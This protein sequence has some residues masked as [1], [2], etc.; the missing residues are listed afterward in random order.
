MA[1]TKWK[2]AGKVVR[3]AG[4]AVA[5]W[6]LL[7]SGG[8]LDE[9]S[10]V[11]ETPTLEGRKVVLVFTRAAA[12]MPQSDVAQCA[13]HIVNITAEEPDPSWITADYTTCEAR[14]DTWFTTIKAQ[15]NTDWTLKEY[16]W[17]RFGPLFKA[18]GSPRRVTT[19]GTVATGTGARLPDQVAAT[20]TLK[21]VHRK[22]WG[23]VYVPGIG[24]QALGS[25]GRWSNAI[26]TNYANATGVL[27]NGL[28]TDDFGLCVFSR[29]GT[30]YDS[31]GKIVTPAGAALGITQVQVDD[32]PDV[33]RRR[34]ANA[35]AVRTQISV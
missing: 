27:V 23:R 26:T 19:K 2:I 6:T 3:A 24:A 4:A 14:L 11:A 17:Y 35:P 34:R 9:G 12:G 16:R 31:E 30:T 7:Q 32:V 28:A 1:S 33:Q 20:I 10:D 25:G 15:M 29:K 5:D 8:L 22:S 18:N 13:F 21:T